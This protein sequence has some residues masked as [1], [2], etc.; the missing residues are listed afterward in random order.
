M[1]SRGCDAAGVERSG[2]RRHGTTTA[3]RTRRR[4]R[5]RRHEV[6]LEDDETQ[7]PTLGIVSAPGPSVVIIIRSSKRSVLLFLSPAQRGRRRVDAAGEQRPRPKVVRALLLL[8]GDFRRRRRS[9]RRGSV[10]L[11]RDVEDGR[12]ALGAVDGVLDGVARRPR[13][14]ERRRRPHGTAGTTMRNGGAT[15]AAR[16]R[17]LAARPRPLGAGRGRRFGRSAGLGC[18]GRPARAGALERDQVCWTTRG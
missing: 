6:A 17:H 16:R 7:V 9:G 1:H 14:L 15:P 2:E 4:R 18:F 8:L 5:R 10:E 13:A 11:L 12:G 3:Q